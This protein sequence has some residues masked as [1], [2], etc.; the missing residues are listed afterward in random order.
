MLQVER[1]E[2][3]REPAVDGSEKIAGVIPF[4]LVAPESCHAHRGAQFPG[5]CLLL[6]CDRARTLEICLCF[7]R[8]R[9]RRIERDLPGHAM[10]LGLPLSVFGCFHCCDRFT[11][12]APGLI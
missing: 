9:L 4:A 8:I 10:D 5:L 6:T 7:C 12:A 2:A 1:I 11:N 3:F